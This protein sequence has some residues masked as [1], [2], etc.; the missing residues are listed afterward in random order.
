[1][2]TIHDMLMHKSKGKAATTLPL[3]K[4]YL[5]RLL[6]KAVFSCGVKN[7]KAII[8]P[9]LSVKKDLIKAYKVNGEKITV[10]HEGVDKNITQYSK[11]TDKLLVK[12]KLPKN[13]LI[14]VGNAYPHKNLEIVI[15]AI[16]ELN[17][18]KD[19]KLVFVIVSA[20]DVF[21]R[22]L[23]KTINYLKAEKYTRLLGFVPDKELGSLLKASCAFIFPS[24]SEGFGLPGLEAL[25]SRTLLLASNIPV[26]KEIYQDNAYFF[27]PKDVSSIKLSINKVLD[28]NVSERKQKIIR[29][30]KFIKRYSWFKMAKQTLKIYESSLGI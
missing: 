9:S 24:F 8:V 6:Y 26:F 12:Y 14:Y 17:K 11:S 4:Y 28:M 10:T 27:D 16:K 30:K 5:K 21:I 22:R 7:A 20:R 25:A 29:A 23:K 3:Y 2:V 13:Y 19:K 1:V 15:R 18:E